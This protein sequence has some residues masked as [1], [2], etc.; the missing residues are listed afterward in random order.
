MPMANEIKNLEIN[1][2]ANVVTFHWRSKE[3]MVTP[4]LR[5]SEKKG[6]NLFMTGDSIL[7]QGALAER[8]KTRQVAE[9]AGKSLEKAEDLARRKDLKGLH[10]TL[11]GVRSFITRQMGVSLSAKK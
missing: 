2:Q 8:K 11:E 1:R 5:V 10:E 3:F 7:I 6:V 9:S 4:M